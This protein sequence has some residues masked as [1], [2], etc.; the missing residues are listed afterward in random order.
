MNPEYEKQLEEAVR[1]ELNT[2]DELQAPAGLAQRVMRAIEL[3]AA[4]PWY[5]RAWQTWPVPLQI[6]SAAVLLAAFGMLCYGSWQFTQTTMFASASHT[7]GGVLDFF[8]LVWRT[9]CLVASS[10]VLAVKSLGPVVIAGITMV[11]LAAY[12]V[13][14]G[15]GTVYVRLAFVRR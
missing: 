5:R 4:A 10:I 13:C 1:R 12:A 8:G 14:V 11:L 7:A 6:A 3:R 2:L 9:V 15:L